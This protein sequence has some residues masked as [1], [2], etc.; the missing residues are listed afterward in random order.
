VRVLGEDGARARAEA[1][2]QA[3][4]AQ[5]DDLG[6]KAEPLRELARFAVRRD[7]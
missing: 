2:L 1:L 3:A 5:L 4:L 6:E 7:R